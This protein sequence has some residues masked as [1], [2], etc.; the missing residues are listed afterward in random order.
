MRIAIANAAICSNKGGS[1]RAAIRL[2]HEMRE[3]GHNVHMLTVI[4]SASPRY[5]VDPC[6]PIHFFPHRFFAADMQAVEAG[7]ALLREYGIEILVSFESDWKHALWQFCCAGTDIPFICS[8]RITPVLIEREFW[9]R[10]GRLALLEQCA[11]IHELLP[12]YLP[13][14]PSHLRHKTF[15]IPNAAPENI[16]TEYPE[17]P[18]GAPVL[19][20]LGRF[21]KEKRPELLLR[22]FAL[23]LEEFPHWRLR[24]A[25][26]G[27]GEAML[28]AVTQAKGLEQ[29]VIIG[30]A[31]EDTRPEYMA[32]N[33]YCLPT[34]HEGFPNTVLEAMAAGLPVVGTADCPAMTSIIRNGITGVLAKEATPEALAEILRPLMASEKARQRMGREAWNECRTK[35]ASSLFDQWEIELMKVV[36][37]KA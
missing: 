20:Y 7:P 32:A 6:L 23:I 8:E 4:G 21:S 25:G 13:F 26:W 36:G 17:H 12:C 22:A 34:L 31:A 1:E 35:Y 19:L 33:I 24:L 11:A 27:E 18:S 10:K 3:R 29:R 14:V 2:A 5:P 9:N 37:K 28:Q 15:V 16:P 30:P